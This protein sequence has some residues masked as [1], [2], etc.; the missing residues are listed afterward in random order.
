MTKRAFLKV[1]SLALAGFFVPG[2]KASASPKATATTR[3]SPDYNY[4]INL[5]REQISN[6]CNFSTCTEFHT[7][8]S[9]FLGTLVR[10]RMVRTYDF[11]CKVEG[12]GGFDGTIIILPFGSRGYLT[13]DFVVYPKS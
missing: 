12:S 6:N 13:L 8:V 11:D 4:V 10:K 1:W 3:Q 2:K 5:V 7:S 9:A